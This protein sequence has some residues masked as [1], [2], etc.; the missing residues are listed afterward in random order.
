[1][2]SLIAHRFFK[3]LSEEDYEEHQVLRIY[4][5]LFIINR[6][7]SLQDGKYYSPLGTIEEMLSKK[8]IKDEVEGLEGEVSD[9]LIDSIFITPWE[10]TYDFIKNGDPRS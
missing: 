4:H 7:W 5:D 2:T 9:E 8:Y 10:Q 3:L 1:M 6:S